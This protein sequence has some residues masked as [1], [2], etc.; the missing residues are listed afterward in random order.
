MSPLWWRSI[1]QRPQ[2]AVLLCLLSA[3][4]VLTSM[5]GPVL[6]RAVYQ[7]TLTDGLDAAQVSSAAS[8]GTSISVSGEVLAEEPY[9]QAQVPALAVVADGTGGVAGRLWEEPRVLISSTTNVFWRSTPDRF[10]LDARIVVLDAGCDAFVI[11]S[12]RCPQGLNQTMISTADAD[13]EKVKLGSVISFSLARAPVTKVTVVGIYDPVGSAAADLTRPG[14]T[15]GVL[16]GIEV[17]PLVI[18]TQQAIELPLPVAITAR[19]PLA[20]NLALD[21]VPALQESIEQIKT[22]ANAQD[23]VLAIQTDLPDILERVNTQARSAQVLILVTAVQALGLAIFALVIVLQRIG[24]ARAA[25]WS[26]GRLRGVPRARWLRSIYT[27]PVAALLVGAPLGFAAG[28]G[29]ARLAVALTLR[30]GTTI[31]PWRWPVLA[32]AGVATVMALGALVAVSLGSV[33]RPLAELVQQQAEGRRLTPLGA[34]AHAAVILLA[35]ATLFQLVTGGQLTSSGPQLGLLAPGL[36]ALAVAMV[37]VRLAVLAVRQV[38]TRPPR[39]LAALVVGRHAA[40]TPSALNPAMVITVGVALAVFASQVFALSVRNQGLRAD[41]VVGASTVLQVSVPPE[42]ELLAAVHAADPSGRQA[43]AVKETATGDS[44][45]AARIVAVD[46][47]RLEAVASW[48]PDWAGVTDLAR[49]LRGNASAPVTIRGSRIEIDLSGVQVLPLPLP[50]PS[51]PNAVYPPPPPT[52]AV[53]VETTGRWETVRLGPIKGSGSARRQ[54]LSTALPCE[55]GCRMVALG[56]LAGTNAPYRAS[57]TVTSVATD[58]QRAG[59]SAGWLRTADRWRQQSVNLT[60]P[61]ATA[62]ATPKG[63][64]EGLAIEAFDREGGTLTSVSPTDTVDPLPAILG[65]LTSVEPVPGSVGAAYG[66]GLDGQQQKLAVIGQASVLPRALDTGVLVDLYSAQGLSDPALS[67]TIDEVWLAPDA[68]PS[69][70]QQLIAQGLRVQSRELLATTRGELERQATTRGAAVA[71][72]V[73]SAALMLTLLA[74]VAA[75]WADAGQRGA[76]WRALREGGLN[77][78]RIRHLIR[79]EIAVPAVLGVIFGMLSGAVAARIAA[80]RLPLVNVT[81]PGPPLDLH[82]AWAPI[83]VIGL[84]T[85]LVIAVIA[86]LGAVAETRSREDR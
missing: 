3:V 71:G 67:Q 66:T 74:L 7:S 45:G 6:V 11:T 22:S 52:L 38:T 73:G 83:L 29:V 46:S 37:A 51:A 86:Q 42:V 81:E 65:P 19:M 64:P 48:S 28:I 2:T 18:T 72:I 43:M 39:S 14:T 24:R 53:T 40:R 34:V 63:T 1:R 82:L 61:D 44:S 50:N 5:L 69:V 31:E 78:R 27:E 68:A 58:V 13:G 85:T 41:A 77:R 36:F 57:F 47:A 17:D 4:A 32:A 16:A 33:R 20:P 75:R 59:D 35:A 56:L 26:V 80:G 30:P 79:V 60:L 9:D 15:R 12:G 70:E 62:L 25:E 76:D 54:L 8:G 21:D 84:G 23:L 49:D 55:Q 10:G